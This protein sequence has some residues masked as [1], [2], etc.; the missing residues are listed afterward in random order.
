MPAKGIERLQRTTTCLA[1]MCVRLFWPNAASAQAR[2]EDA[3]VL[4]LSTGFEGLRSGMFTVLKSRTGSWV[5]N[6]K[7]A[8]IHSAH[9]RSGTQCLRIMGGEDRSCELELDPD[10][11]R[12]W[13]IECDAGA[14]RQSAQPHCSSPAHDDRQPERRLRCALQVFV[15]TGQSNSLG[16]TADPNETDITPGTHPADRNVKFFW[17]NRSTRAGDGTAVLYGTSDGQIRTLQMQQGEG[18]NPAFW[19]P[20]FGFGR[21]LYECG[22]RNILIVKASRGGGGNSF[23][24]KDAANNHMYGHVV[25]TVNAAVA[26]LPEG[27]DFEI[28]A[29]LYL[30]GESDSEA[31]AAAAGERLAVLAQNL[32]QDLPNAERMR[33]VVGGIA[34]GGRRDTVRAQQGAL[35]DNDR[36]IAYFDNTDLQPGLYDRLH[37]NKPAKLI[38]GRRFAEAYL[39][40]P[41]APPQTP[42]AR[43]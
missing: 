18:A 8:E 30:Q 2:Q 14:H 22:H 35:A 13:R 29:L 5:S 32:R 21:A 4:P 27:T 20:E 16:T 19:G 25:E 40:L 38:V 15:L 37:F 6:G 42:N 17:A 7:D 33:V 26:L 24:I 31:E 12:S 23:W 39:R 41:T 43:R 3:S 1:L 28:A 9:R 11:S 36:G 10:A 34:A